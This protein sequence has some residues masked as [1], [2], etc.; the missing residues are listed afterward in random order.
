M[1]IYGVFVRMGS[2]CV[3]RECVFSLPLSSPCLSIFE[4]MH[5]EKQGEDISTL[6]G[7]WETG[8][9]KETNYRTGI[10]EAC[11]IHKLVIQQGGN[12]SLTY[13]LKHTCTHPQTP[14]LSIFLSCTHFVTDGVILK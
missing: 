9:S 6:Q 2:V 3:H 4:R 13:C 8:N 11:L 5:V 1:C 14:V 12:L 10:L 7:R